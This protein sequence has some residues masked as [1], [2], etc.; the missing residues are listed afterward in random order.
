M[1]RPFDVICVQDPPKRLAFCSR[2]L[3]D[4]W[5]NAGRELTEDDTSEDAPMENRVAFLVNR[6]LRTV[7]WRVESCTNHNSRLIATLGL[8]T[9]QGDIFVHNLYSR[10]QTID[11]TQLIET[12][13]GEGAHIIFGDFNE[14]H[15]AWT[16]DMTS[17]PGPAARELWYR[18]QGNKMELLIIPGV[19][20]YTISANP[21]GLSSTIAQVFGSPAIGIRGPLWQIVIVPGFETDHQVSQTTLSLE[22][23]R[24]IWSRPDWKRVNKQYV[25]G[26]R[27]VS[28]QL[29]GSHKCVGHS[30]E[31]RGRFPGFRSLT[32]SGCH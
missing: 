32:Q 9:E 17:K 23:I 25:R 2:G 15:P 4:T 26:S 13:T 1:D 20:T 28:S 6:E 3:Y 27:K 30:R 16:S 31:D 7:D 29:P 22:L 8:T 14:H 18:L 19:T 10:Y 24:E 21:D 11:I 12:C 5:Y